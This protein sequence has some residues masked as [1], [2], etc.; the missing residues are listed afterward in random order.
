MRVEIVFHGFDRSPIGTTHNHP[1][2]SSHSHPGDIFRT[3]LKIYMDFSR[4]F[5]G[6]SRTIPGFFLGLKNQFFTNLFYDEK[7]IFYEKMGRKSGNL[8]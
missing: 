1:E 5:S 4:L 3:S 7:S 2:S 8:E 6:F